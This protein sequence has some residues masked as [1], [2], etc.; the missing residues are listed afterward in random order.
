MTRVLDEC[1]KFD[2]PKGIINAKSKMKVNI[3]FKPTLRYI[4]DIDLCCLAREKPSAEIKNLKKDETKQELIVEKSFISI[5]AMGDF[6]LIKLTDVR[7]DA[8]STSNLWE[9][10][11]LT[12]LNKEL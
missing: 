6:P 3:T 10:F 9:R 12:N 7:N 4:F 1:F 11:H 2:H 8:I 5:H